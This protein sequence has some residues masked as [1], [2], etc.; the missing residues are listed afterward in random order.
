MK[1]LMRLSPL[2]L[3]AMMLFQPAHAALDITWLEA[4]LGE[5]VTA[6]TTMAP[7]ILTITVALV[8]V[9]VIFRMLGWVR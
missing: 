2:F 5:I 4:L 9:G 1:T 6:I 3:V 8:T 7:W